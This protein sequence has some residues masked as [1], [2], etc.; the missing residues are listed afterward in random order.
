MSVYKRTIVSKVGKK[1]LYWYVEVSSPNG[2]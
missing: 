2:K 1:S